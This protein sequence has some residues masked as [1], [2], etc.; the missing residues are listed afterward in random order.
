[1]EVSSI[2]FNAA[3]PENASYPILVTPK[4]R[5]TFVNAEHPENVSSFNLLTLDSILT[6]ERA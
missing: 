4:G 3:H 2:D 5:N 6:D 1:M